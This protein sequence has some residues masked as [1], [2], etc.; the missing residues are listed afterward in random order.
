M[1]QTRH[2]HPGPG[3]YDKDNEYTLFGHVTKLITSRNGV[4]GSNGPRFKDSRGRKA[5]GVLDDCELPG[6]H[7]YDIGASF[8]ATKKAAPQISSTFVSQTI[9]MKPK[10]TMT[11]PMPSEFETEDEILGA[12]SVKIG[13][14]VC[15]IFIFK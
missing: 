8:G 5:S 6:P 11:E 10:R 4:F 14:C 12:L 7:S 1:K 15:S 13:W 2:G 9:R 3:A